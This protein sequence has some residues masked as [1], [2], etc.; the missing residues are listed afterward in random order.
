MGMAEL[1]PN[2]HRERGSVEWEKLT[3][4][5][6]DQCEKCDGTGHI[7]DDV[8]W[9]DDDELIPMKHSNICVC[10]K[11]ALFRMSLHEAGL[12]REFWQA[13]EIDPELNRDQFATVGE[14]NDRIKQAR[15]H[16]LGLLL[17]GKNGAGKTTCAARVVIAATRIGYST[18][19]V[20]FPHLV[21]GWRRA[22]KERDLAKYLDERVCADFLVLDEIGKEHVTNDETFVTSKLDGILRM[23]RGD[24]FPTILVTNLEPRELI[25]RYGASMASLLSDRYKTLRFKPGDFRRKGHKPSWSD[26]LKGGN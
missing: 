13:D 2:R 26:L 16:G 9:D 6:I 15:R 8:T 1:D 17:S 23:R 25:E 21:D 22:W 12:P 24:M 7:Y 20:N 14:Y 4:T 19:Y 11:T 5:L 10:K 18:A 3:K